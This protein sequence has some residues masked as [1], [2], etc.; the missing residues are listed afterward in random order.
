MLKV[1]LRD[2]RIFVGER[3]SVGFQRT[4]RVPDD[5]RVYPLPPGLG[6]FPVHRVDD[7]KARVP[8]SWNE[9]GG[10]FISLYQREAVWLG[11]GGVVWKPNAV[12][13]GV[14]GIN[15]ISG[16]LWNEVLSTHPQNYIVCPKQPWLDGINAGHGYIRQFVAMPLAAG[17]TVEGQITGR[18]ELGGI[19]IL[20]FEPK[21]G[22]FPEQPPSLLST[23]SPAPISM[24]VEHQTAEMGLAAG[25]MTKQKI[26]PDPYGVDAWS[27][28]ARA[29]IVVH[30]LNSRRYSQL[31]G[32]R[33]PL[34]PISAQTYI[35]RGFPWFELYDEL[36]GDVESPDTLARTK[37]VT[38]LESEKALEKG[39]EENA[40]A[41]REQITKPRHR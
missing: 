39:R 7:Y 12:K 17:Y 6:L 41:S 3:F 28:D 24:V 36:E 31:T 9:R 8:A 38:Q 14:G 18:E 22:R 34:T 15:A 25:G 20:V 30:I 26:Y 19:Q 13:I 1:E 33:P 35:E 40:D 11:F 37:S 21:P 32:E 27:Q 10:Y 2:N 16:E 23:D 29:S 5:G 4:L